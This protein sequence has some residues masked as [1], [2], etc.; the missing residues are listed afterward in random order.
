[1]A[2]KWEERRGGGG[3]IAACSISTTP[4]PPRPDSS[5]TASGFL[6]ALFFIEITAIIVPMPRRIASFCS[7]CV[8]ILLDK[9][10]GYIDKPQS[11][12]PAKKDATA[13]VARRITRDTWWFELQF[14]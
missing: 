5:A 8:S 3:A 11:K 10:R 9:N 13:P 12:R 1:M 7:R 6:P 4:L 2:W 14:G